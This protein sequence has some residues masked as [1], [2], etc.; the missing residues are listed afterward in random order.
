MDYRYKIGEVVLVRDDL[1]YGAFY[2]MMSGPYSKDKRNI[3]T[4]D[5]SELHGQLVHIKAYTSDG[6]YLVEEAGG[7]RWTDDMFSGSVGNECYCKSLL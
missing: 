1:K 5:M 2:D 3:A 6:Q 4:L 7:F